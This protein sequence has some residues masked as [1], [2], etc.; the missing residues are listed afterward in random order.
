MPLG[1]F[2]SARDESVL[3]RTVNE[4]SIL[5]SAGNGEDGGRSDLLMSCFDCRKQIVSSVIHSRND[6]GIAFCICSPKNN[7]F[8]KIILGFEGAA[9]MS[10]DRTRVSLS[11]LAYRMSFQFA[12]HGPR[13]PCCPPTHCLLGPPGLQQ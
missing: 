8:V 6:I 10:A 2:D 1:K 3:R 5:E 12:Q 4:R 7:D 11:G 13:M 9:P